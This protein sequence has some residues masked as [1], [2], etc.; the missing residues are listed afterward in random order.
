[1]ADA[2]IPMPHEDFAPLSRQTLAPRA[3]RPSLSYWQD[4]WIR[5]RRNRQAWASLWI[6]FALL[7]FTVAGP[8]LWTLDPSEQTLSRVSEPPSWHKEAL[9][10]PPPAPY[11]EELRSGWPEAPA[12][13]V[14]PQTL[15][16]PANF[17]FIEAPSIQG[18]RLRWDPVPGASGYLVYRV[19][20][21]QPADSSALGI[22][23]GEI[24]GGNHVSFEDTFNL[25][26]GTYWYSVVARNGDESPRFSGLRAELVDGIP[27]ESARQESASAQP[28]Q[29]VRLQSHPLGTDSLGRDLLARLIRGA[30]VSLFIGL[31]APFLA[32]ALGILVGGLAGYHGGRVDQ[33]LMRFTDFV[34]ALPFL[35]FMILIQVACGMEA[36][37]SGIPV[38][39][40]ALV[41][42]SW[43]SMAR[44]V[45]GQVLQLRQA[46]YV[47]AARL[48]G[49]RPMTLLLRHLL[50]NTLGVVLVSLTFAIPQA[51]FTEAFLSFIGL[52]VVPPTPSW[53]SL[54]N[55]GI[56]TF[57]TSPHEFVFPALL[58][59]L[60]VLAFNLLGDG[61][62]DALDPRLR[63]HP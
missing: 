33:L 10:L 63:S 59:S 60:T 41:A 26:A 36:G 43:T 22:P 3:Q 45:R 57:L 14:D 55:D 9:V 46:D 34:M 25:K 1:M 44:L 24:Q 31:L 13:A 38:M 35:L 47:Q 28:G 5:L 16:A 4:A 40:L 17:A 8:W 15:A 12:T 50:P 61:L 51:I 20:E 18:V 27:L 21:R 29:R 30:R 53:G 39:L 23:V 6:L 37:D 49:A 62:R 42:L 11:R 52:G 58:I 32:G 54:C 7:L 48:L 56:Q 19:P 2:L